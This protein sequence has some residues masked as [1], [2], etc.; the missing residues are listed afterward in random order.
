MKQVFFNKSV[1][2]YNYVVCCALYRERNFPTCIGM[3]EFTCLL[4]LLPLFCYLPPCF[5]HDLPLPL[6]ELLNCQLGLNLV[7]DYV[8]KF[9]SVATRRQAWGSVL[10]F[11]CACIRARACISCIC[12][13][14]DC[15]I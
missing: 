4:Y 3:S 7:L 12:A 5:E 10:A 9:D 8:S 15:I 2:D 1:A 14:Y 13:V 11:V 6:L